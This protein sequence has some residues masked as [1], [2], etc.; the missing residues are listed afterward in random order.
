MLRLELPVF[1]RLLYSS[2][3]RTTE[4]R[5]LERRDVNLQNGVITIRHTKSLDEHRVALHETMRNALAA[6]DLR[7]NYA[8]TNINRWCG[9]E[10]ADGWN[11]KLLSLSRS[12]GHRNIKNTIYYYKLVPMFAEKL[13]SLT[14][15]RFEELMPDLEKYFENEENQ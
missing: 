13:E 6:Y 2:G 12:M 4:A 10:S 14:A 7:S 1:F 9:Q 11:Q 8:V 5:L 3:M 15:A